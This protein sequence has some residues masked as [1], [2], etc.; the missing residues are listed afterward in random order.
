MD[1]FLL[2]VAMMWFFIIMTLVRRQVAVGH[3]TPTSV[4]TG[5]FNQRRAQGQVFPQVS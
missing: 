1:K 3:F 4:A 5:C 2:A